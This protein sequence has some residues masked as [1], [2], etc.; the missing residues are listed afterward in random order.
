MKNV[1]TSDLVD[2]SENYNICPGV[3][4]ITLDGTLIHHSIPYSLEPSGDN[5][6]NAEEELPVLP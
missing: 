6:G 2:T 1:T 5:F 4:T 3:E